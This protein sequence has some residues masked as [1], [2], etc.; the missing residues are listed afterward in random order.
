MRLAKEPE[1]LTAAN[2]SI[3]NIKT[4]NSPTNLVTCIP[5]KSLN[6]I[7]FLCCN[8]IIT[9][10][11]F[12]IPLSCVAGP[13]LTQGNRPGHKYAYSSNFFPTTPRPRLSN[14][15]AFPVGAP[16]TLPAIDSQLFITHASECN[17]F[18][19]YHRIYF[20]NDQ[21]PNIGHLCRRGILQ[22]CPYQMSHPNQVNLWLPFEWSRFSL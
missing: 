6:L 7:S 10:V 20:Q 5:V 22:D 17:S 18:M 3:V 11:L 8:K 12:Y 4:N 21:T 2:R 13:G 15:A 1:K 9:F 19:S 14:G 16:W